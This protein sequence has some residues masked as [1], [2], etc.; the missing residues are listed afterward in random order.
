M[1]DTRFFQ[2][3]ATMPQ[4]DFGAIYD[5][6]VAKRE[7]KE[8]RELE[9]MDSFKK[10]RGALTPG[11]KD[12]GQGYFNKIQDSLNEGDMS[13]DARR[14][15]TDLYNQYQDVMASGLQYTQEL[16]KREAQILSDPSKYNSPDVLIADL[17][18]LRNTDITD[19]SQLENQFSK[20][21]QLNKFKRFNIPTANVMDIT[22]EFKRT[23]NENLF[24]DQ[25]TGIIDPEKLKSTQAEFLNFKNLDN[26]DL[27]GIYAAALSHQG[28]LTNTTSDIGLVREYANDPER[29][30]GLIEYYGDLF[31]ATYR[32]QVEMDERTAAENKAKQKALA[33]AASVFEYQVPENNSISLTPARALKEGTNFVDTKVKAPSGF[34]N[35]IAFIT[36][37][38]GNNPG[39]EDDK[40]VKKTIESIGLDTEGNSIVKITYDQK[41]ETNNFDKENYKVTEVVPWEQIKNQGWNNEGQIKRILSTYKDMKN[42]FANLDPSTLASFRPLGPDDPRNRPR[43]GEGTEIVSEEVV[44]TIE[45]TPKSAVS[46]ILGDIVVDDEQKESENDSNQMRIPEITS[47]SERTSVRDDM[48]TRGVNKVEENLEEDQV[49]ELPP[50]PSTSKPKP[51]LPKTIEEQEEESL[52]VKQ[53]EEQDKMRSLSNSREYYNE[54]IDVAE[55]VKELDTAD[56]DYGD[57]IA[58]SVTQMTE[59]TL[60]DLVSRNE[61]DL[62]KYSVKEFK[63]LIAEYQDDYPL[64]FRS[65]LDQDGQMELVEV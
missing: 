20:L 61:I 28:L 9:Y 23:V 65:A 51:S 5:N 29:A 12:L 19:L 63:D 8:N 62:G 41:I 17:D 30:K 13:V 54:L 50:L 59:E 2:T 3:T 60:Q 55:I 48:I 42:R 24:R 22:S 33:D 53:N 18:D 25:D 39:Y 37:I 46:Q 52:V 64:F 45:Q 10:V 26:E 6:A 32:S 31:G 1:A 58:S 34:A 7:A 16:N 14:Y 4:V 15:R 36:N 35:N 40:G 49:I 57:Q 44:D 43:P 56:L 11:L 47:P 38:M 27:E 21:P